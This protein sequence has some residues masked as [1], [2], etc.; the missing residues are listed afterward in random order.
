VELLPAIV[1]TKYCHPFTRLAWLDLLLRNSA[2][3]Q[4]CSPLPVTDATSSRA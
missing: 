2:Q 1:A 3:S 4:C